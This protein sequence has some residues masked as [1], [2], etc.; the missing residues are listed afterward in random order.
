VFI[1]FIFCLYASDEVLLTA[2]FYV[3]SPQR[4]HRMMHPTP[5]VRGELLKREKAQRS[6]KSLAIRK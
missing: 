3:M 6:L 4:K 2:E 1:G 5:Q